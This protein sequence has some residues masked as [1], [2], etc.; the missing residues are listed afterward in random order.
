MRD[1]AKE[2]EKLVVDNRRLKR[3]KSEG[4]NELEREGE[5]RR[6]LEEE[7]ERL[8]SQLETALVKERN[9]DQMRTQ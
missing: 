2:Q 5:V 9:S 8:Q 7:R 6:E 4:Q 3:E 1:M